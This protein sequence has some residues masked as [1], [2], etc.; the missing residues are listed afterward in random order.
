M[1]VISICFSPT[2]G[3]KNVADILS[4]ELKAKVHIDLTLPESNYGIYRFE[5]RDLCIMAVPSFGGRVPETAAKRI[6][7][8][9]A[10]GALAVI[11]VVYGNRAYED[12]L[13]ELNNIVTDCGFK[14]I[15]AIGAVAEHSVVR[16][17]GSSR[18]DEADKNDLHKFAHEIKA[19]ISKH[20]FSTDLALP[21]KKPYRE[22]SKLPVL[23]KA[24]SACN[25]CG[26]CAAKCPVGA[27]SKD[28]LTQADK[29]MCISCMRCVSICPRD[30]RNI[31]KLT[32]IGAS[33]ML[34]KSCS[35]RKEN[36]LFL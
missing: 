13:L 2:G 25:S 9:K 16:K 10:D 31:S 27:I 1:N 3:T 12:T 36:E 14:V 26:L 35:E 15:G 11:A 22:Y 7:K 5:K 19:K 30:A 23:P 21:G 29:D 18:P 8:M 20:E 4:N 6:S 24:G 32:S 33:F 34:R 17:Y 28:N